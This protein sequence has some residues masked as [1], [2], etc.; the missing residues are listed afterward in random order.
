MKTVLVWFLLIGMVLYIAGMSREDK[1]VKAHIV[2][3]EDRLFLL[4]QK[5]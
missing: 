5:K 1:W 4:E 2:S 3:I